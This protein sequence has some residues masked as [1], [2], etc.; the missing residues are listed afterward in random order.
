MKDKLFITIPTPC[1]QPWDS[2]TP[3]DGGRHCAHC[4]TDVIDFTTWTDAAIYRFFE[5]HKDAHVCGMFCTTQLNRNIH[6]PHQ[7]HSM[8]YRMAIALGLTIMFA[9]YPE[10]KGYAQ[11]PF[12]QSTYSASPDTTVAPMNG[13]LTFS[14]TVTDTNKEPIVNA[15]V[16]L[17]RNGQIVSTASTD[18]D[19][20]FT[21]NNLLSGKYQVDISGPGFKTLTREIDIQANMQGLHYQLIADRQNVKINI[22][23]HK[24]G[25]IVKQRGA[26]NQPKRDS[27]LQIKRK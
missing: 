11:P 22:V 9:H 15:A 1:T 17:I 18:F 24:K 4:H 14:G 3:V 26:P 20:V 27:A 12:V 10:G 25:L 13:L 7:P 23:S 2:M 6:I 5:D 21:I 16:K 19:G 8:L